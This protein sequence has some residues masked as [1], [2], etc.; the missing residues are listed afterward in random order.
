M[1]TQYKVKKGRGRP[2]AQVKFRSPENVKGFKCIGLDKKKTQLIF[3][4]KE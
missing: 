3:K 4:R 1:A 2:K